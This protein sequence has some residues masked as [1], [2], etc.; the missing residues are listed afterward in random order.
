MKRNLVIIGAVLCG[1]VVATIWMWRSSPVLR[2][3]M[4]GDSNSF[5]KAFATLKEGDT[6]HH[7]RNVLGDDYFDAES[8]PS[9]RASFKSLAESYPEHL[10]RGYRDTDTVLAYSA[11]DERR[12][13][14]QVRDGRIVEFCYEEG[15]KVTAGK[16]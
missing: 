9:I 11:D 15:P 1:I 8:E 14:I 10:P 4:L 7:V 6:I 12:Y 13:G 3:R 16:K 2:Y 5:E